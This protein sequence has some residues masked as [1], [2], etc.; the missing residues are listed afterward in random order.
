[1][2]KLGGCKFDYKATCPIWERCVD[3]WMDRDIEKVKYLQKLLGLCLT[4]ETCSRVF[5]IFYGSGFNG[6]S[7]CVDTI[8]EILGDYGAIGSEDL[9]TEKNMSQHPCDIIDLKG[10]RLVVVDE[11]KRGMKLRT[12]LVK[13]MTGDHKLKGR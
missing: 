1:M 7:V 2:T 9:L 11:T 5:P 10:K 4:G 3:E 12:S 13:R 6:K 8:L